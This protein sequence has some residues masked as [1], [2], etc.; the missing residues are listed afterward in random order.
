MPWVS[1]YSPGGLPLSSDLYEAHTH[2]FAWLRGELDAWFKMA[3]CW[4][5]WQS[6]CRGISPLLYQLLEYHQ[7]NW[8]CHTADTIMDFIL[9]KLVFSY[10]PFF[11]FFLFQKAGNMV[12]GIS[13]SMNHEETTST[14]S[15]NDVNRRFSFLQVFSINFLSWMFCGIR[16]L[17]EQNL[18]PGLVL[19]IFMLR[20]C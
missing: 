6:V 20:S 14:K 18:N 15:R 5:C 11:C 13:S 10:M 9:I 12:L 19:M 7:I 1:W 17:W 2:T 8:P 16:L 3:T 4:V